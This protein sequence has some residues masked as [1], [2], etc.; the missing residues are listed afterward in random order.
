MHAQSNQQQAKYDFLF[1]V[2][3]FPAIITFQAFIRI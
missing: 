3:V 2:L 1:T